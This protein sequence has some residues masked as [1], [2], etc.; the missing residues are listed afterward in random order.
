MRRAADGHDVAFTASWISHEPT[1]STFAAQLGRPLGEMAGA[2]D[3]QAAI[4][5]IATMRHVQIDIGSATAS[6]NDAGQAAIDASPW[7][8]NAATVQDLRCNAMS[9]TLRLTEQQAAIR[10][11]ST[12]EPRQQARMLECGGEGTGSFWLATPDCT[13]LRMPD[14]HWRI[15]TRYRCGLPLAPLHTACC[16]PR[17]DLTTCGVCV[18][19]WGDH[20]LMCKAGPARLRPHR[21]IQRR[22]GQLLGAAGANV[23]FERPVPDMYRLRPDGS[24]QE[25]ILDV[26]ATFP[27]TTGYHAIDVSIRATQATRY[28]ATA[29]TA[30]VPSAAGAL[31]KVRRYGADVLPVVFEPGGRLC[32]TG[33][34]SLRMLAT[35]AND[36]SQRAGGGRPLWQTWRTHLESALLFALADVMLLG[37]GLQAARTCPG[38]RVTPAAAA[39]HLATAVLG[40]RR[41]RRTGSCP[42]AARTDGAGM[43]GVPTATLDS[44]SSAC[45]VRGGTGRKA[46]PSEATR[47]TFPSPPLGTALGRARRPPG[48]ATGACLPWMTVC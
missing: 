3:V 2:T 21:A 45:A 27:G 22:L 10:V 20:L 29:A 47:S 40:A 43:E 37:L 36:A 42:E 48:G 30:G 17:A 24:V 8:G 12:S 4:G 26:V 7:A 25:A 41:G 39:E 14:A 13:A 32:D 44:P 6:V 5:R 38:R 11:W 18:D 34:A 23:D 35:A 31:E 28:A 33:L 1:C 46:G 9:R 15:A 16:V 19:S